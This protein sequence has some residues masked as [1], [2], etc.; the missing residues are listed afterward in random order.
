[1]EWVDAK[2]KTLSYWK[3]LREA[4]DRED[5]VELLTEINAIS[6]LCQMANEEAPDR[7]QRCQHCL[8]YQQFGGC[9]ET[10]A[11]MSL[12]VANHDWDGL[13]AMIDDFTQHLRAMKVPP[14][15]LELT[16]REFVADTAETK[17]RR[18]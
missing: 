14:S 5:E 18:H 6:D 9:R 3:D 8:F 13:R 4:I 10:N 11:E 16:I 1:M 17:R 2:A 12:K 7:L 15:S